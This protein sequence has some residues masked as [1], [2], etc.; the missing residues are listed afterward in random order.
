MQK[1]RFPAHRQ[2]RLA[3]FLQENQSANVQ[4]ICSHFRISEPTAR[5]DLNELEEQGLIKR[6]HGGAVLV[7]QAQADL[8]VKART[9]LHVEEK[10]RI[11]NEA[12]QLVVEGETVFI[13]S[14]TTNLA[15]ARKL[16]MRPR[17]T[18]ISSGLDI[19]AE[20]T[21]NDDVRLYLLGGSYSSLNRSFGGA[22][23]SQAA[24]QMSIDIAFFCV[25]AIDIDRRAI[26]IGL[27]HYA[28]LQRDIVKSAKRIYVVAD[29][30]KFKRSAFA[31]IANFD[32][33]C[34]IITGGDLDEDIVAALAKQNVELIRA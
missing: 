15:L 5:R 33:I 23:A 25:S 26:S 28:Q 9:V 3:E 32:Q 24:L 8:G 6:T 7:S 11:A 27:E 1:H 22:M 13:D 12:A 31:T 4:Q 2:A 34:G 10:E 19:A 14:G 30:S 18:F 20:L 21:V 17:L 29:H 16:R